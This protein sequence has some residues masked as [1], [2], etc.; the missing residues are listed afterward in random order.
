MT[1]FTAIIYTSKNGHTKRYA[2][3][4]GQITGKPVFALK[5]IPA[6]LPDGSPIVYLGWIHASNIKGYKKAAK[7]FSIPIVCGVGLCDTGTLIA[8]VRKV[9]SIP[10]SV[11]LFTLQG[12]MDLSKLNGID[13]LLISMLTKGLESQKE[14]SKQDDRMLELL[15]N[16][17]DY[18]SEDNLRELRDFLGV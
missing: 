2:E 17:T 18:V 3:M 5:N 14:R 8:E 16:D 15:K 11:S 9:T 10:D 12:G 1:N 7:R 4:L 13:K 6:S